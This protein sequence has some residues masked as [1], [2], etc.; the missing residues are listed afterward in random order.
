MDPMSPRCGIAKL[1]VLVAVA[2]AGT[3]MVGEAR[4]QPSPAANQPTSRPGAV[5]EA[6]RLF[7]E[8][9][10]RL[11]AGDYA[12]ACQLLEQSQALDPSSGTLLNLGEC[13]ERLGRTASAWRTFG[14]ASRLAGATGR[15][16]RVQVAELRRERL[17][18][19]LRKIAIV[20]PVETVSGLSLYLD[21]R[22]LPAA[23]WRTPL[24]VDPGVHV[25]RASAP[26]RSDV[27]MQAE[28]PEPG[29]T[30]EV[31]VLGLPFVASAPAGAPPPVEPASIASWQRPAAVAC[32]VFGGIGVVTGTVFGLRSM[33]KHEAS[34]EYCDG[35]VCHDAVGVDLMESARTAGNI[36]TAAFIVGG[37]GLGAAGVLWF[38]PLGREGQPVA[39][40]LGFGPGAVRVRGVW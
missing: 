16:D 20:P 38:V 13:Y 11:D 27:V 10:T 24:P 23:E 32:A 12:A 26:A 2:L 37:L 4:A 34:D 9:V 6:E 3:A 33:S 31:T 36:S 22:E 19:L 39:A 14:E 8:G 15:P 40:E 17:G 29:A 7:K 18:A 5:A 1:R 25:V 30:R 28:A 35:D 21:D